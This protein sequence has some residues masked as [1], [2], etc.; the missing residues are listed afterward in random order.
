MKEL[1]TCGLSP[2]SDTIR[3][4]HDLRAIEPADRPG[5]EEFLRRQWGSDRMVCHGVLFYPATLAGFGAFDEGVLV[6]L[7]TYEMR[8]DECE[9]VT[10]NSTRR[11][12]GVGTKLVA[13][14]VETA[15]AKRLRRVCLITTND[16]L[17]ALRFYQKRGFV[18]SAV[19]LNAMEEYR[20]LKPEIPL[21][22]QQGI[23]LRDELEL[24]LALR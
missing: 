16:N 3:Q 9:I 2:I 10:L 4:V 19:R 17:N 18:L 23:P 7:A 12:E 5:V 13:A 21:L 11:G 24:E 20:R 15:R 6:G 8:S 14:V 1:E 22:G